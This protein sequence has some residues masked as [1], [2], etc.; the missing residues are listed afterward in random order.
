MALKKS[1]VESVEPPLPPAVTPILDAL[2]AAGLARDKALEGVRRA[3]ENFGAGPEMENFLQN[4]LMNVAGLESAERKARTLLIG[5]L[6]ALA[7]SGKSNVP[8]ADPV[9]LA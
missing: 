6:M 3:L 8:P 1:A 2:V 4:W 5:E 7:G 9:N